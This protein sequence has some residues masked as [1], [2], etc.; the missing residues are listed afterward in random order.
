MKDLD[1]IYF[2]LDASG[3]EWMDPHTFMLRSLQLLLL[4][5]D[6]YM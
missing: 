4:S 5:Q 1:T 6:F 2:T 3:T